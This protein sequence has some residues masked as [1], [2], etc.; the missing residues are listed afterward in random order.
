MELVAKWRGRSKL[1]ASVVGLQPR[2]IH[3]LMREYGLQLGLA[4]KYDAM[5]RSFSPHSLRHA[6]ATHRYDAGMDLAILQKLLGHRYLTTT[7]IYVETSM[8]HAA[9]SY[10]KSDPMGRR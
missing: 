7:M 9:K 5:L 1:S 10:R 3:H 6:F 8:R 4:Q 2:Q